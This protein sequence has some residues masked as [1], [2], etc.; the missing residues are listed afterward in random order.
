MQI[1]IL[2]LVMTVLFVMHTLEVWH[3]GSIFE[4][5]RARLEAGFYGSPDRFHVRLL[6][7]MFCLSLWVTGAVILCLWLRIYLH[8]IAAGVINFLIYTGGITRL[9]NII[10]DLVRP[11]SRTP[12]SSARRENSKTL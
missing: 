7:C 6:S 8:P 11:W 10:H 1:P 12:D 2:D 4:D 3:H 5:V 9:A